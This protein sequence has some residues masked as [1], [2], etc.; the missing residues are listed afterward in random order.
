MSAAAKAKHI[1]NLGVVETW[2]KLIGVNTEA[3]TAHDVA[4]H[5]ELQRQ[6]DCA[7][8]QMSCADGRPN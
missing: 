2:R 3:A 1:E 4:R 7:E 8:R 5:K 6:A